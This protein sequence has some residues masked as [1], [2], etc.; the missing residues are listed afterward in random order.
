VTLVTATEPDPGSALLAPAI[1]VRPVKCPHCGAELT[2]QVHGSP[3]QTLTTLL[4][5]CDVLVVKALEKMG[6][7][8]MRAERARFWQVEQAQIPHHAVHT[9]WPA[10][11]EIVSKAIK[12]AWSVVPLLLDTHSTHDFDAAKAVEILD[13]YVHDL[14]VAGEE[15][16][17]N[18][19]AYRVRSGL[20]L[21]VFK[22]ESA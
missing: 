18:L 10:S 8:L 5:V 4:A 9:M 19:L 21:P 13:Q 2:P 1:E 7:Y 12:G 15:H 6:W 11:D 22:I 20:G 3:D 17:L 14:V 16:S